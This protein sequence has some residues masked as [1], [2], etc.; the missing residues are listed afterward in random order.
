MD[1]VFYGFLAANWA[2]IV[3]AVVSIGWVVMH[4]KTAVNYAKTH[5]R[6]FMLAAEKRAETLLLENG[7]AKFAWVVDRG[8]DILPA[9]VRIFISKP[10][11][12]AIVQ[13]LFD[14]AIKLAAS[15]GVTVPAPVV[16]P[17]TPTI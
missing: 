15:H 8:Y 10:A 4:R 11:F 17:S 7:A 16:A 12:R 14:E 1:N 3:T 2:L 13:A 5:A 9:M 6:I